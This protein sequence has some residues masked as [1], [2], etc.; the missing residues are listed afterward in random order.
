M[1]VT[2]AVPDAPRFD[3]RGVELS[4]PHPGEVLRRVIKPVITF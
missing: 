1:T 4:D 3:L 2:T